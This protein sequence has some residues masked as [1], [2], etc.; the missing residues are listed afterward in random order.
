MID[1]VLTLAATADDELSQLGLG[2]VDIIG[3]RFIDEHH[4]IHDY[5]ES[6]SSDKSD[7]KSDYHNP[8]YDHVNIHK[9]DYSNFGGR[10]Y[11][12]CSLGLYSS[13]FVGRV[14]LTSPRDES[15]RTSWKLGAWWPT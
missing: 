5:P 7:D 14:Q 10:E 11:I 13:R 15:A 8:I 6:K 3:T 2:H 9:D 12:S 1:A 4:D